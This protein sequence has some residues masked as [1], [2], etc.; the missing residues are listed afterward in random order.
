MRE[1]SP[2]S[3]ETG[4]MGEDAGNHAYDT[5]CR[6]QKK[7]PNA[8]IFYL[9]GCDKLQIMPR[10]RHIRELLE[11]FQVLTAARSGQKP[12]MVIARS[13]FL[14]ENCAGFL[15]FQMPDG[16]EGISSSQMRRYLRDHDEQARDM[17]TEEVWEILVEKGYADPNCISD[18][19]ADTRSLATFMTR[20]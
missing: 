14:Y 1:R 4:E 2:V 18:L 6:V 16:T 20:L 19:Q 13:R 10:W 12:E 8:R 9:A 17:V 15:S 7:H 11:H 5:L 3:I